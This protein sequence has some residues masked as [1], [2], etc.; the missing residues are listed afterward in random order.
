[1]WECRYRASINPEFQ[2]SITDLDVTHYNINPQLST[3]A[4]DC[5]N[6]DKFIRINETSHKWTMISSTPCYFCVVGD[7]DSCTALSNIGR[8][9]RWSLY[10]TEGMTI[11]MWPREWTRSPS[12]L[13]YTHF[14]KTAIVVEKFI[15]YDT[16]PTRYKCWMIFILQHIAYK[17]L[18]NLHGLTT[19]CNVAN[20][21]GYCLNITLLLCCVQIL[22]GFVLHYE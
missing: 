8:K 4:L 22:P 11:Y 14:L 16:W 15:N 21:T 18:Q 10:P 9:N 1:M 20:T 3:S 7:A 13:S 2:Y 17:T 19:F 6:R 5:H 12:K